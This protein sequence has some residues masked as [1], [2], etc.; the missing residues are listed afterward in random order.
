MLYGDAFKI[1]LT[2][3]ITLPSYTRMWVCGFECGNI[4]SLISLTLS[5]ENFDITYDKT[6]KGIFKDK[7]HYL[8]AFEFSNFVDTKVR[9]IIVRK[10]YY[11]IW[12]Y[13]IYFEV[14]ITQRDLKT[15][16]NIKS[17]LGK[18]QISNNS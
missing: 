16:R 1:I 17:K 7:N 11:E 2:N 4:T 10:N 5:F 6:L 18:F 3:N 13:D 12:V 14:Q 8:K 9:R 15:I